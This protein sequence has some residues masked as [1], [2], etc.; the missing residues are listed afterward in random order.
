[1]A[2]AEKTEEVSPVELAPADTML[3]MI[4]AKEDEIKTR[5]TKADNGAQRMVEDAKLDASALKREAVTAEV[6]QD[7]REKELEKAR[8][9]AEKVRSEI[10]AQ[11][12]QV[13]ARGME[14]IE[15]AAK[16]VTQAVLPPR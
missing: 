13:K 2:E 9:D 15:E 12:V 7:L 4:L 3:D 1:M 16:I 11:A 6:G 10:S 5:V 14:R 8:K